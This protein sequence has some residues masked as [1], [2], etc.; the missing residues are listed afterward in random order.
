[1]AKKG[2]P[3]AVEFGFYSASAFTWFS[4][5]PRYLFTLYPLLAIGLAAG[6]ALGG[7]LVKY[8]VLSS[9]FVFGAVMMF[10]WFI[11][12]F[13][14]REPEKRRPASANSLEGELKHGLSQ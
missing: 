3:R 6:G 9:V 2:W 10:L 13:S 8:T 5:E 1:M 11:T 14:M 4:G 7:Y 12:A